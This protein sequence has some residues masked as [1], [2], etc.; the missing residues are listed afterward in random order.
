MSEV[1]KVCS[2]CALTKPISSF[3]RNAAAKDGLRTN[4][5]GCQK[6]QRRGYYEA[7]VDELRVKLRERKQAHYQEIRKFLDDLKSRTPCFDC[8]KNYP[9]YVMDFD[10]QKDKKFNV[11]KAVTGISM[12]TLLLEIEKCEIVCANCH[13]ERTFGGKKNE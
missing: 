9:P 7:N 5:K 12:A 11:A 8:G 4:C 2:V 1:M 10:H 13:R 6:I 3:N